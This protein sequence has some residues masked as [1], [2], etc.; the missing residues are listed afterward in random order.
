MEDVERALR[1]RIRT[2][3]A[4]YG[5]GDREPDT[6]WDHLWRVA[7]IAERLGRAEE[8]DVGECRLAGLFHDAGK[9][10]DGAYH[11]DDRP[12]ERRSVEVLREIA[13]D[14]VAPAALERVAEAI[15]Q[16]YRDD[17]EPTPL[18]RVLFDADNL[19]KLGPLGVANYFIKRGL[20]GRGAS[21][22][23]PVR[24]TVELTYARHAEASMLTAAGRR[25]AARRAPQ[26]Q[27]FVRQLLDAWGEDGLGR[28][29]VVAVEHAGLVLDVVQPERCSCGARVRREVTAIPGMKCTEIH[30]TLSCDACGP[31]HRLR[32][33]RPR[34]AREDGDSAGASALQ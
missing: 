14:A 15:E 12:E 13:G 29:R 24:L 10:N 6:L 16:L 11:D 31:L 3:E 27:A 7:A 20:R 1:R 23:L 33:C 30:L 25:W 18:A 21:P 34:L 2:E 32:F 28:Y 8:V 22:E 19:D 26:T 4:R 17:P 9:F 5:G